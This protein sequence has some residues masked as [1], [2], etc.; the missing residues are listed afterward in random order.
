MY[1]IS[2]PYHCPVI[3][4]HFSQVSEKGVFENKYLESF[5]KFCLEDFHLQSTSFLTFCDIFLNTFLFLTVH[6][7]IIIQK[8]EIKTSFHNSIDS[9]NKYLL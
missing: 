3:I 9:H 2:L 8:I 6:I 4:A 1:T 5:C 7:K